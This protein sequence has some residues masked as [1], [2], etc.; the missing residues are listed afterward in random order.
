M[1]TMKDVALLANVS[2]ATVSRTLVKPESVSETTRLR[3]EQAVIETGY[4]INSQARSLRRNETRTVVVVVS[5]I[6]NPFYSEIIKGIEQEAVANDYLVVLGDAS[7]QERDRIYSELVYTRQADGLILLGVPLPKPLKAKLNSS[8]PPLVMACEYEPD[9]K[10][11]TV[12]IDNRAAAKEATEYLI[13]LGHHRIG[14]VTGMGDNPLTVCRLQGYKEALAATNIPFDE[15]LIVAEAYN[16]DGGSNAMR[17]FHSLA[18]PPTAI[19]CHADTQAI[20]VLHQARSLGISVPEQLSVMGF[21]GLPIGSY[22]FPTLTTILQPRVE[23][24]R[25]TMQSLMD[26]MKGLPARDRLL[27]HELIIRGSVAMR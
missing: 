22:C 13:K 6:D 14:C 24:G 4:K 1:A 12:G 23:L 19:F 17:Y 16:P 10:L 11:P 5:D 15:Q 3:V 26:S 20:G 8:L 21:D 7:Q 27:P 18:E 9:R 25:V 2:T